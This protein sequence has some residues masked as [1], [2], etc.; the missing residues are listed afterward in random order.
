MKKE[1]VCDGNPVFINDK[2]IDKYR[3][4]VTEKTTVTEYK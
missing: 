2:C 3:E 4:Q 1:A